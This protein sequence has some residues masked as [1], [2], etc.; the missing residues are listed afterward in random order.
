MCGCGLTVRL[1]AC[2]Q[3]EDSTRIGDA[4]SVVIPG[5]PPRFASPDEL[6]IAYH[7]LVF[8][9]DQWETCAYFSSKKTNQYKIL[10]HK[11]ALFRTLRCSAMVHR[12]PQLWL[13]WNSH[14][15]FNESYT[16]SNNASI[17]GLVSSDLKLRLTKFFWTSLELFHTC[18][19]LFFRKYLFLKITTKRNAYFF[20]N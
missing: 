9:K 12:A 20:S 13:V 19:I 1:Y 2:E 6:L 16:R 7:S 8:I 10:H 11:L 17:W 15:S 4:C 5:Q 14:A 3:R 18:R